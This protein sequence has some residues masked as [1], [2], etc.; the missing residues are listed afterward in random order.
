VPVNNVDDEARRVHRRRHERW[1]R[2]SR[3]HGEGRFF[4]AIDNLFDRAYA[5]SVIVN[6]GSRR[7]YEPAADR[8][9][10]DGVEWRWH[11]AR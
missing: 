10:A 5:G 1:L 11:A 6:E 4:L 3:R 7:Y 2:L 8:T 9:F